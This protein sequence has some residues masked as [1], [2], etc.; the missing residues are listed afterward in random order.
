MQTQTSAS[1]SF[2]QDKDESKHLHSQPDVCHTHI[3]TR[4]CF[5]VLGETSRPIFTILHH[6]SYY[7]KPL[8]CHIESCFLVQCILKGSRVCKYVLHRICVCM[9]HKYN[10]INSVCFWASITL[11]Q[12]DQK[13]K[14]THLKYI[15]DSGL[16][17]HA[18]LVT[19]SV[20]GSRVHVFVW[21]FTEKQDK[22]WTEYF[23]QTEALVL[24]SSVV[25]ID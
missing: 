23:L 18:R 8:Y 14:V 3:F 1:K 20:T 13:V 11:Y 6:L 2:V 12:K 5:I 16:C 22:K 19:V 15:M 17:F 21:A 25:Q 24:C 4:P 9:K 7:I 10:T